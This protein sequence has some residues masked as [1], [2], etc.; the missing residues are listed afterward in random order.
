MR[1]FARIPAALVAAICLFGFTGWSQHELLVYFVREGETAPIHLADFREVSGT[2]AYQGPVMDGGGENWKEAH[3]FAGVPILSIVEALGGLSD[4]E[5]LGVVAADGWHKILPRSVVYEETP[6]GAAVLATSIDGIAAADWDDAPM[7]VFL[8]KDERFSNDDMLDAF[9]ADRAHYFGAVPSTTGMMVKGATYLVVNYD[10]APLP[11][12]SERTTEEAAA[13]EGALLT[14]VKGGTT[15]E[16]TLADLEAL[17][18]ITGRGTFTNSAGVDYTATYTGV[19]L[20]ALVG[21]VPS[22]STVRVTAADGYSM[23]YAAGTIADTSEGVWIVAFKEDGEYMPQNPGPLRIV[24]VGEDNPHFTSS[25]SARMVARI[26]VLGIYEEYDLLLTGTIDRSF[27]RGELEAGIGCPCHTATVSAT[28]KGETHTYTGLPLWRLIAYVDDDVFPAPEE[29]IHYDDEDF[30]DALAAAGY[31]IVLTA[32]DGYAQSVSSQLIA[33]DDRFIVAFKMD[34]VFLDPA[35]NGYMRFVYDDSVELP[36][37]VSLKS[38]K[39]LAEIAL[40]L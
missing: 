40:D 23:N 31:E 15:L 18:G 6:A 32:S 11:L 25:L 21:N 4:D 34:G 12:P 9:G 2:V 20:S 19:P 10:G 36:E 39:F 28:G 3:T 13:P 24:Q 16:Y 5:T 8:P 14:L 30:C 27:S 7:L 35:S 29:G 17:E 37:G 22:D 38:V 26:E 1:K 33:R